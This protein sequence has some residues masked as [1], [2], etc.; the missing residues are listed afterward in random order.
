M[1]RSSLM[2][3]VGGGEP[4]VGRFLCISR[5][6]QKGGGILLLFRSVPRRQSQMCQGT[7]ILTL[8]SEAGNKWLKFRLPR[9]LCWVMWQSLHLPIAH[10]PAVCVGCVW[11]LSGPVIYLYS[12]SWGVGPEEPLL[13]FSL[14]GTLCT[15]C[16]GSPDCAPGKGHLLQLLLDNSCVIQLGC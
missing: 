8:G 16:Q 15:G 1:L 13:L 14:Q 9:D 2:S 5:G 10:R 6:W 11:V 7:Q 12:E 4:Y 3:C